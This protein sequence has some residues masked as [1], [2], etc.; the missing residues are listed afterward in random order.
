MGGGGGG[1]GRV[2]A[3]SLRFFRNFQKGI[4]S[5]VLNLPLAVHSSLAEILLC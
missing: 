1:G 5:I 4:N 2:D 3:T